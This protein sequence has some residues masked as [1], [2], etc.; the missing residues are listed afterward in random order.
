MSDMSNKYLIVILRFHGDVLLT[1]PMIDNI[2]LNEPDSEI[3]LLVYKGTGSI[4]E[5]EKNIAEIIEIDNASKK[6]FFSRINKE[7]KLNKTIL[8]CKNGFCI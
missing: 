2:K 6:N 8:Y 4:L 3:D 1:K 5:Q 7:I